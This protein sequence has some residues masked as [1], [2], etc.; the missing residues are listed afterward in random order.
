MQAPYTHVVHISDIHIRTGDKSRCRFDDY[1][2]VFHGLVS[3]VECVQK[4]IGKRVLIVITGDVFHNKCKIEPPG[5]VLFFEL[6]TMLSALADV[7]IIRGNHD[8]RQDDAE[9]ECIDILSA[10]LHERPLKR[11]HYLDATGIWHFDNI[12]IG[13]VAIQ[14]TLTMGAASAQCQVDT[15]PAFPSPPPSIASNNVNIALFHGTINGCK[16]NNYVTSPHGY[17]V[18][19]FKEYD[20]AMLGDVHMRQVHYGSQ[21]WG[22]A[23][24]LVQQNFGEDLIH[25]GGLIWDLETKTAEPFNIKCPTGFITIKTSEHA[26]TLLSRMI[27]DPS[28]PDHIVTRI[29][30]PSF[31]AT[32]LRATGKTVS[33]VHLRCKDTSHIKIDTIDNN[34]TSRLTLYEYIENAAEPDVAAAMKG[35][36]LNPSTLCIQTTDSPPSLH[37]AISKRNAK[38]NDECSAYTDALSASASHGQ[39]VLSLTRLEWDWILCYQDGCYFTFSDTTGKLAAINAKNGQGKSSFIEVVCLALFGTSIHHM[40]SYASSIICL[41]KPKNKHARTNICFGLSGASYSIE[42]VFTSTPSNP[43]RLSCKATLKKDGILMHTGKTAVDTWVAKHVGDASTFVFSNVV[44]QGCTESFFNMDKHMQVDMLDRAMQ[45]NLSNSLASIF[46]IAALAH[47]S[48]LDSI[49]SLF[50]HLLQQKD[51]LEQKEASA[52]HTTNAYAKALD[53]M[54]GT[55]RPSNAHHFTEAERSRTIDSV[56]SEI[57]GMSSLLLHDDMCDINIQETA[58]IMAYVVGLGAGEEFIATDSKADIPAMYQELQDSLASLEH[59]SQ[60]PP[61]NSSRLCDDTIRNY[62]EMLIREYGSISNF[63]STNLLVVAQPSISKGALK[64]LTK[65]SRPCSEPYN[66]DCWACRDRCGRADESMIEIAKQQTELWERY[67]AFQEL[68]LKKERYSMMLESAHHAIAFDKWHARVAVLKTH[69]SKLMITLRARCVTVLA[70]HD[71]MQ[72]LVKLRDTLA[73]ATME[74]EL[75]ELQPKYSEACAVLHN[76]VAVRTEVEL[77]QIQKQTMM[78]RKRHIDKAIHAFVGYRKWLYEQR[79]IPDLLFKVNTLVEKIVSHDHPLALDA[80]IVEDG[81]KLQIEW[82]IKHGPQ[83]P[84]IE[85]ASGFQL[86]LLGLAVRIVLT[87]LGGTMRSSHLFL[88]EG[89]TACDS[90]HLSRV[91]LFLNNLL[92]LYGSV[93]VFTHLED[94][95]DAMDLQY[96]IH[97]DI[98]HQLSKICC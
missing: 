50:T 98:T 58:N 44:T 8:Y 38:I 78:H 43:R 11:V 69:S 20:I 94:L 57:A 80:S 85:K 47:A 86:F 19:W 93:L 4:D 16:L 25:H 72:R 73:Y 83:R 63:T 39:A 51:D 48:T 6:V 84:P 5:I 62:E 59:L 2:Q 81:S 17:P 34:H 22:Y 71:R 95:R 75:A 53:T 70:G 92:C 87:E 64:E 45:M 52:V 91:P 74:A 1:M 33:I 32:S 97:R 41:Q 12:C 68:H 15:L 82:F 77:L 90:D 10:L 65:Q 37:E 28:C 26:S 55:G 54:K 3:K 79:V 31:D 30:D 66:P 21:T 46:K 29:S 13:L 96:Y 14:D 76:I 61:M 23:G 7:V 67:D 88:D 60:D 42:R 36:V 18:E 56:S 89:F 27:T 35:W 40:R 49:T 24:S 9:G